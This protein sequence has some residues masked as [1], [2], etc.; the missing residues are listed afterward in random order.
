MLNHIRSTTTQAV[1]TS[2]SLN[3]EIY[4]YP[5]DSGPCEADTYAFGDKLDHQL[6]QSGLYTAIVQ[7]YGLN[8]AGEYNISL[9]K[10]PSTLRPGIYNPLPENC[11]TINDLDGSF[12]WNAVSGAT[13]YD[14]YFGEGVIPESSTWAIFLLITN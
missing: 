6:V 12:G 13:G 11:A 3:T 14:L 9:T 10:I 8:D 5:P 7:D 2:G 1:T 4:L